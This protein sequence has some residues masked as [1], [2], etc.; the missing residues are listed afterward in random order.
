MLDSVTYGDYGRYHN[1]FREQLTPEIMQFTYRSSHTNDLLNPTSSLNRSTYSNSSSG[2][3]EQFKAIPENQIFDETL[4]VYSSSPSSSGSFFNTKNIS[5]SS[6]ESHKSNPVSN[7][8]TRK[9][10]NLSNS[11]ARLNELKSRNTK[12]ANL[13]TGTLQSSINEWNGNKD[14]DPTLYSPV[15][16][17]E[18]NV[19]RFERFDKVQNEIP[20]ELMNFDTNFQNLPLNIRTHQP[21]E[22]LNDFSQQASDYFDSLVRT[23]YSNTPD[24]LRSSPGIEYDGLEFNR[25]LQLNDNIVKSTRS[26]DRYRSQTRSFEEPDIS[27]G[28]PLLN[29]PKQISSV[30]SSSAYSQG[31]HDTYS[32]RQVQS[33]RSR[34]YSPGSFYLEEHANSNYLP[35]TQISNS[36]YSADPQWESRNF[37]SYTGNESRKALNR[38]ISSTP[39]KYE[40]NISTMHRTKEDN[41]AEIPPSQFTPRISTTRVNTSDSPNSL[42]SSPSRLSNAPISPSPLSP[43]SMFQQDTSRMPHPVVFSKSPPRLN[44]IN[45]R[46]SKSPNYQAQSISNDLPSPSENI[47]LNNSTN[48]Y[49]SSAFENSSLSSTSLTKRLQ[50][51]LPTSRSNSSPNPSHYTRNQTSSPI[52]FRSQSPMDRELSVYKNQRQTSPIPQS[53]YQSNI[54]N[55]TQDVH[56]YLQRNEGRFS[57]TSSLHRTSSSISTFPSRE[58]L[59][60]SV[61]TSSPLTHRSS[62]GSLQSSNTNDQHSTLPSTLNEYSDYAQSVMD[63]VKKKHDDIGVIV[64]SEN[65]TNTQIY[66]SE[67]S[68]QSSFAGLEPPFNLPDDPQGF[69]DYSN[70]TMTRVG[71]DVKE[72]KK[73]VLT[74]LDLIRLEMEKM[75]VD[76]QN[77][78]KILDDTSEVVEGWE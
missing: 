30:H 56:S 55:Q 26:F 37:E 28:N 5:S 69:T 14:D 19:H 63:A 66:K 4:S 45:T 65:S 33:R 36:L 20:D 75:T 24:S 40:S 39:V 46:Y 42:F 64:R 41:Y 73:F 13:K 44:S 49:S 12:Y 78:F 27:Y 58:T 35:A 43:R 48:I 21:S 2:N 17:G 77:V 50:N 18:D 62:G 22:N 67:G 47:R 7:Q 54:S 25:H 23:R 3:E 76:F 60:S 31:S 1:D 74:Q 53:R 10:S 68:S 15:F 32:G 59:V 9:N 72:K 6:V 70:L 52:Q 71:N 11:S 38:N 8:R 51:A 61:R 57:P 29:P 16:N 34:V